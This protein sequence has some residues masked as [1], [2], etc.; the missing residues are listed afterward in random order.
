MEA[1]ET[2]KTRLTAPQCLL[3]GAGLTALHLCT[4]GSIY[5]AWLAFFAYAPFLLWLRDYA[6]R[7]FVGGLCFGL[8]Y[9]LFNMFWLGQF[10]GK[11]TSSPL[12]GG[13]VVLI[14]G[15][16]WGCFYGFAA[17]NCKVFQKRQG[18]AGFFFT[19]W[20]AFFVVE[21]ARTVIPQLE[22]PFTMFGDPLAAYP[23]LAT[24]YKNQIFATNAVIVVNLVATRPFFLKTKFL[25]YILIYLALPFVFGLKAIYQTSKPVGIRVGLGQLG[26]DMAYGDP[27]TEPY[28]VRDAA[29]DLI[30][31]AK[32]AKV[33][34]LLFPEAVASFADQPV[35]PFAL[36]TDLKVIFGASRGTEKR[37]QSAY[38]WDGKSFSYTDKNRLVVFGEYV[39]FRGVIP[40]PAGFQ[41]PSGDLVAGTQRNL[42]QVKEKVNVGA[43]ICF[44]SLFSSSGKEFKEMNADFLAVLSL[45]DWY[46]GTSAIP[47]LE[48]AAR[49][50]AVE[51]KKWVVRVGSLGKTMVIDPNGKVIQELPIG[52]RALLT[53]NL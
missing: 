49:W 33:D 35:T 22:F 12:I 41:L 43:L 2:P 44:E 39:P 14:C 50:R 4:Y 1:A 48:V 25:P 21:V 42:L 3:L 31:Q 29:E 6:K 18:K 28:R 24:S 36:P 46:I 45:D 8:W 9:G 19:A 10:V 37:F 17:W 7:P 51:T 23:L 26:F 15:L 38:L 34:V 27:Q 53:A 52:S 30:E 11:W 32:K 20:I 13:L 47:R 16:I 40:Y 5:T